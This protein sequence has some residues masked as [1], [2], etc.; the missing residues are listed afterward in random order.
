MGKG[1]R[2][3]VETLN[4]IYDAILIK[5][6]ITRQE[7]VKNTGLSDI[8]IKRWL[9]MIELI[10]EMPKI[11][12]EKKGRSTVIVMH[13]RSAEDALVDSAVALLGELSVQEVFE[14]EATVTVSED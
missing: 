2:D 12:F 1:N 9:D 11:S 8:T 3:R 4:C 14:E 13:M 6:P 5:N 7:L 10:Q